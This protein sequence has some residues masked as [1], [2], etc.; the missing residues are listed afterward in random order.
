MFQLCP[1]LQ[2]LDNQ[3]RAGELVLSEDE[4]DFDGAE[5]G[6]DEFEEMQ[7]MNPLNE[8]QMEELRMRG[9]S[10][11]DYMAAMQGDFEGGEDDLDD[12]FNGDEKNAEGKDKVEGEDAGKRQR[13]E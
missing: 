7:L 12:E 1:T 13:T 4:D 8:D 6:E 11:K 3:N 9:I 10:V 2:V 5:G